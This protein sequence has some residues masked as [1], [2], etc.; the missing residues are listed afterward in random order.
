VGLDCPAVVKLISVT[1]TVEMARAVSDNVAAADV[2]FMAAAVADYRPA[3]V[4]GQKMKKSEGVPQIKLEPTEDILKAVSS[5]KGRCLLVGFAAETDNVIENAKGKLR[6]KGLDL[7]VANKVGAPDSG[8]GTDT[9]LAAVISSDSE[10]IALSM[11]SKVELSD[12]I[13]DT[14]MGMLK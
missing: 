11:M 12:E 3:E 4:A 9:D 1:T 13:L 8:F 7:I 6:E 5:A 2:L 14:V 10:E